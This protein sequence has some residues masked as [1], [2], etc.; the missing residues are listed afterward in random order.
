[1][2]VSAVCH[3]GGAGTTAA[4]LRAGKPCI[5]I[6][7]FGDQFFWGHIVEKSGAGPPPVPAKDVTVEKLVEAFK[8]VHKPTTQIAAKRLQE[9]ILLE[10]GCSAAVH[11]FH[12]NL[13]ISQMQSDLESTYAACFRLD[14]FNLQV[15]RPVAEVL[16]SAGV[17]DESQF[18]YHSTREWKLTHH[19]NTSIST[20]LSINNE[21]LKLYN[22][23][24][25]SI[26]AHDAANISGFTPEVCQNI[27]LQ[28]MTLKNQLVQTP[29]FSFPKHHRS[30]LYTLG[31]SQS[32]DDF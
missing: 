12:A 9:A 4:A 32:F 8:Y 24:E 10:D 28:F 29:K 18:R 19:N 5:T 11:S 25:I 21:D 23:D 30:Q 6:P 27:L 20:S 14:E 2:I 7:F 13:P 16:L 17:V 3:H 1:M 26:L 22:F 31:R 15:S